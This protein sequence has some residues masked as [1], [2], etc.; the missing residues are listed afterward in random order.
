LS[1]IK[2]NTIQRPENSTSTQALADLSLQTEDFDMAIIG[3]GLAG[4]STAIQLA[5]KNYHVVLFE[6]EQYPFHKVCGEYISL[7][8]WN[9]LIGLGL[10]LQKLGPSKID[11][12]EISSPS[13]KTIH[14][15]LVPGGFGIS[16]Y[17]LD[18]SLQEIAKQAGV[19]IEENCKVTDVRFEEERF[20]LVTASGNY[21]AK[22]AAGCYGK[23][24]NL[25]IRWKRPFAIARKNKLNNYVGVKYHV[26]SLQAT[27]IISLHNF[28]G[29]YCG[30][31]KIEGDKF[32]LCYLTNARNLQQVKGNIHDL[33]QRILSQNPQLKDILATATVLY[34]EPLT[35]SQISFDPKS[36]VEDH[37]LMIGD[38]AGMITPLC[39]NGMSMALH[40]SKLAAKTSDR[41]L[42]G[43]IAR[44]EMEKAY[45]RAW[46]RQFS[47]RLMAGRLIQRLFGSS[48]LTNLFVALV[49]PFPGLVGFL[50]RQTH[51]ESF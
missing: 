25:D 27:G 42:K 5:R 14:H 11:K 31:V 41:F 17:L 15:P 13:G 36:Q 32:C 30:L 10:D 35:I 29:G 12:L 37:M 23:R 26:K 49:K 20:E 22:V 24:S 6:K 47:R 1:Y 33:E 38:A 7:E 2:I 51:G 19:R 34:R 21:S 46:K 40:A 44:S 28:S 18:Y 16:R 50:I 39:G 43:E 4:L 9:F 45:T 3:G 8:S 48:R